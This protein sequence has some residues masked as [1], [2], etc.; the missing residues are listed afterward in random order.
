MARWRAM[1][2]S[3]R[4]RTGIV[5]DALKA[6]V[7]EIAMAAGISVLGNAQQAYE[8]KSRHGTGSDGIQWKDLSSKTLEARV[9]RRAPAQRI[10]AERAALAQEI[11]GI[12]SGGI[13]PRTRKGKGKV[14]PKE[15]AVFQL[16]QVRAAL[17]RK[18]DNLVIQEMS[19]YQIGV[20]TGL[21]RSAAA[22]GFADPHRV[23]KQIP[24]DDLGGNLFEIDAGAVVL[25]YDREYS[26]YF[27]YARPL[28]PDQLPDPW[29]ED[30][31]KAAGEAAT[32]IVRDVLTSD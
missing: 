32:E 18:L 31:E 20:D 9:R 15:K 2:P 22:P 6:R 12:L 21:Q 28:F 25:G 26:S 16:R 30:A 24:P 13:T 14:V 17:K 7:D 19:S 3:L 29:R 10:V 11:R 1:F 8:E 23:W 4:V 5:A 27:D